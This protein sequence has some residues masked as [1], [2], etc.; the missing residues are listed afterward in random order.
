[1]QFAVCTVHKYMQFAVCAVHNYMQFAVCSLH[2]Y[3][4]FAV[5]AVHIILSATETISRNES[6]HAELD[7]SE[8]VISKQ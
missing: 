6:V 1:M 3:V 8:Y 2:Y 5:C 4:Q 7:G